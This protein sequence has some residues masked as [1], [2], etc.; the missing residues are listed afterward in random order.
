MLTRSH[1]LNNQSGSPL[2]RE[3]SMGFF[4]ESSYDSGY[5]KGR[6]DAANGKETTSLMD[7]IVSASF[8]YFKDYDDGYRDGLADGNDDD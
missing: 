8:P 2:T 1:P 4:G 5:D 6:E 7:D 3:E